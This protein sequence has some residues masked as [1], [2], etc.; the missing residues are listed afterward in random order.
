MITML[1]LDTN[2]ISEVRRS[3]CHPNLQAWIATQDTNT[4]Y[5]SAITVMEIERGIS[6]A[7][8][9]G[10]APQA[11]V[12]T[13]WLE[14]NVLPAFTDRILP[15][16][17]VI[18]RRTGR[19]TWPDAREYRDAMIAATALVHGAAV[20]TRNVKHFKLMGVQLVNPWEVQSLPSLTPTAARP[21][22]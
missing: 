21:A 20:A 15:V 22:D 9:R 4:L 18:A 14:N 19:L 16:D 2:V 13:R 7:A 5:I 8:Q 3:N 10:D 12:F 17:H 6:Q 11:A 1:I